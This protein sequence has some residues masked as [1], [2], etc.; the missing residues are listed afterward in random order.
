MDITAG[1]SE[2][3]MLVELAAETAAQ[4]ACSGLDIDGKVAARC[5]VLAPACSPSRCWRGGDR[6][7]RPRFAGETEQIG[8]E[9]L[10]VGP[11][12]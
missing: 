3:A 12:G 6:G 8:F 1:T 2:R 10:G 11:V 9:P 5:L 7:A 4:G